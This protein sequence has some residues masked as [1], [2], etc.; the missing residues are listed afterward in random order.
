VHRKTI[1]SDGAER[2]Q[3][4]HLFAQLSLG[5]RRMVARLIDELVAE[6]GE[7]LMREGELGHEVVF[8]EDGS[9]DVLQDGAVINTV[10]AGDMIGELAVLETGAPRTATVVVASPLRGMVLTS[11]FMRDLRKHM[12]DIAQAVDRAAAEHRERDRLRQAAEPAG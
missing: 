2:L 9:A 1:G 6:P 8:V 5:Q 12:P 3:A 7:E 4:I 11:H 10:G